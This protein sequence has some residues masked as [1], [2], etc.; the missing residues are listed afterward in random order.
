MTLK[1]KN[2]TVNELLVEKRHLSL[3]LATAIYE[4]QSACKHVADDIYQARSNVSGTGY[5]FICIGCGMT[6]HAWSSTILRGHSEVTKSIDLNVVYRLRQ[7]LAI[8]PG[9]YHFADIQP[10]LDAWYN[11]QKA[12]YEAPKG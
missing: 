9:T 6:E 3:K 8:A 11:K 2:S 7:G 1:L 12:L 5:S 4:A 10:Q